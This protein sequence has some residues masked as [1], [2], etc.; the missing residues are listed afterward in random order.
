MRYTETL[1]ARNKDFARKQAAAGTLMPSLPKQLPHVKAVIIGCADMRVDPAQLLQLKPGEAVVM[2]NIGGRVTPG[3]LQQLGLLGRIGEVAQ[4]IPGG[5]GEFHIVVLHHTDCGI[6][7]LANNPEML[8]GYFEVS[9]AELA[10]KAVTDPEAAVAADVKALR[11]VPALPAQWMI[12][13]QVYDVAT[14]ALRVVV[15]AAP[16]RAC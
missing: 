15:P 12:S 14:G 2:R 1:L 5:G 11:A 9:E 10:E 16:L 7:R 3:L 4:A 6:T 13:G 8:A